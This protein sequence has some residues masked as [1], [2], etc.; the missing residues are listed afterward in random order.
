MGSLIFSNSLQLVHVAARIFTLLLMALALSSCINN[1][2][3]QKILKLHL[4]AEN[5]LNTDINGRPSPVAITVYQLVNTSD[6]RKADYMSLTE[7]P[8]QTLGKNLV[9]IH[10]TSIHPGQKLILEYPITKDE[11]AF[12]V[13]VGYRVINESL[14]QLIYEYPRNTDSFWSRFGGQD[15]SSHSIQLDKNN[16]QF[17]YSST[18]R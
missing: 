8:T 6:F 1:P 16:I 18:E 11:S 15:V 5:I 4:H 2:Q 7:N 13:V 17:L 10:R 14:W 12:G 3:P 9:S